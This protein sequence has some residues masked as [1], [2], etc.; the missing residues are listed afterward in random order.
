MLDGIEVMSLRCALFSLDPA[1][2]VC[3][4]RFSVICL[5]HCI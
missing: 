1:C 5:C 4:P 3:F 2:S